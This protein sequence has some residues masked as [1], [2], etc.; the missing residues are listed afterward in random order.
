MTP[1]VSIVELLPAVGA[2]GVIATPKDQPELAKRVALGASLLTFVASLAMLG[3]FHVHSAR[4]FQLVEDHPWIAQFGIH[5]KVGLDGIALAM[6]LLTTFLTPIVLLASW[7]Q[8]SRVKAYFALFL[9]LETAM[10]GVF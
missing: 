7:R 10:V 8:E 5:Y 4:M 9:V 2:A 6:V 1:W 3:Q